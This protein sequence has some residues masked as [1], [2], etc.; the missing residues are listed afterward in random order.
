M[1]P[2]TLPPLASLATNALINLNFY[3]LL[4]FHHIYNVNASGMAPLI[5]EEIFIF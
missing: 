4:Y 3:L 5:D 2:D 1:R